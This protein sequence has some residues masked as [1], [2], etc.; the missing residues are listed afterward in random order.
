MRYLKQ[1][2]LILLSSIV[3]INCYGALTSISPSDDPYSAIQEALI[4][5]QPGDIIHLTEGTYELEDSLSID[6][7]DIILEGEGLDKTILSFKN[8]K[9]GAQGLSVTS[10][11]VI[12]RDF[13]VENAKGD[14]IK[15]KGVDGIS[16]II[17]RTEWNIIVKNSRAEFNVAGIEIENSYYADVFDNYAANNTGGILIF[18]LPDIPQQG[19]HHIRVFKNKSINNNTDNFAPEGNIVGEVPRGTGIIVQANSH[20]EIFDN[21]IGD[22]ETINIAI[23]TYGYETEDKNYYPHPRAIQIHGN[24]FGKSGYNPDLE[25]GDLAKFL[26]EIT[27]GDMPDIFWDGIVPTHQII[28]GQP[29]EDKI[30]LGDNGEATFLTINGLKYILPFF[31]PIETSYDKFRGDIE[32]LSPVNLSDPL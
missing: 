18:D 28:L 7:Q 2:K 22:N 17:V 24:R 11:G 20:V 30:V 27:N 3:S 16:F 26:F 1:F 10:D 5:A 15:V 32:P 23:V 9:S 6:V 25:T 19:G 29:D 31:D 8:Q 4:L 14:A 13:A 12:L 21:D